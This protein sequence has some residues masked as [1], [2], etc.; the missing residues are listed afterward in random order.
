MSTIQYNMIIKFYAHLSNV[1]TATKSYKRLKAGWTALQFSI[2]LSFPSLFHLHRCSCSCI[3]KL[4][5]LDSRQRV[6]IPRK[7]Q[8]GWLALPWSLHQIPTCQLLGN[9]SDHLANF[10]RVVFKLAVKH[11]NVRGIKRWPGPGQLPTI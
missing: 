6:E 9:L 2:Q 7:D 3:N 4:F 10:Q 5:N 1:W 8:H 11:E